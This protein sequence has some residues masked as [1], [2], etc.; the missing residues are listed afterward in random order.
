MALQSFRP[1]NNFLVDF[2]QLVFEYQAV[3]YKASLSRSSVLL[4]AFNVFFYAI[5]AGIVAENESLEDRSFF[6]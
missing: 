4:I 5:V 6:K 3:K 1:A 2:L